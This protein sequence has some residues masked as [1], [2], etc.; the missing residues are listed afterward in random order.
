ME[1]A[2][3]LPE[4]SVTMNDPQRH[5]IEEL[6]PRIDRIAHR[7]WSAGGFRG[8]L[9]EIRSAAY[10][11]ACSAAMRADISDPRSAAYVCK[12]AWGAALDSRRGIAGRRVRGEYKPPPMVN[13]RHFELSNYRVEAVS[14]MMDKTSEDGTISESILLPLSQ[15]QEFVVRG[16]FE[17][18]LT[19]EEIGDEMDVSGSR[20]YQIL[21]QSFDTMR[22]HQ[23][24]EVI[25]KP[26]QSRPRK[27]AS[28]GK[29]RAKTVSKIHAEPPVDRLMALLERLTDVMERLEAKL[30]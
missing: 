6:V 28:L 25:V 20:V 8:E 27:H 12:R 26:R 3:Q 19:Q 7:I 10:E 4:E 14:V 30:E 2:T 24:G 16:Y 29:G 9:D 21:K 15:S 22:K 18:G 23:T 11:G 1:T 5:L 17:L 13:R